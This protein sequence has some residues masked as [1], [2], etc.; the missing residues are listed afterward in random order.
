MATAD[1]KDCK[2]IFSYFTAIAEAEHYQGD[3]VVSKAK[4]VNVS[5]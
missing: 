5:V 2:K 1:D 3:P 4:D